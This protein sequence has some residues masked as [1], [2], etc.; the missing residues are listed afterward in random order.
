MKKK[1]NTT[2]VFITR[3]SYHACS[4]G[5]EQ[6][7]TVD[8]SY[9]NRREGCLTNETYATADDQRSVLEFTVSAKRA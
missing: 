9:E 4:S 2:H 8:K 3:K 6:N 7:K 5:I 1:F